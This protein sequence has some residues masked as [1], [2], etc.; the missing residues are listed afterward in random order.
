ML[1]GAASPRCTCAR[2]MASARLHACAPT[3][4]FHPWTQTQQPVIHLASQSTAPH[5]LQPLKW[6]HHPHGHRPLCTRVLHSQACSTQRARYGTERTPWTSR[7]SLPGRSRTS[8]KQ[9]GH[10]HAAGQAQEYHQEMRSHEPQG[11]VRPLENSLDSP[12][13]WTSRP[14]R[15]FHFLPL[16]RLGCANRWWPI[17]SPGQGG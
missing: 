1:T 5:A 12:S 10:H 17:L 14:N 4:K 13:L 15:N 7:H 9:L 6:H 16:A 11:R 2:D 8:Q 3:Q